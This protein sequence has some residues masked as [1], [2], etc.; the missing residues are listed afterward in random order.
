MKIT[1]LFLI[2]TE[3]FNWSSPVS[4]FLLLSLVSVFKQ[5]LFDEFFVP[6]LNGDMIPT[7]SV[8]TDIGYIAASEWSNLREDVSWEKLLFEINILLCLLVKFDKNG[9]LAKR[10]GLY[11]AWV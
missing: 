7:T 1:V 4:E 10:R 11:N 9:A 6:I 3:F 8:G 2:D 5:N